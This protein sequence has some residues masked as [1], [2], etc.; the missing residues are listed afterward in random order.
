MNKIPNMYSKEN[1][2]NIIIYISIRLIK[3][4]NAKI[5]FTSIYQQKRDLREFQPISI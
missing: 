2:S 1:V 4:K 5:I 3:H